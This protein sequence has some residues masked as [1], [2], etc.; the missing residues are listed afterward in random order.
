MTE[1]NKKI[2]FLCDFNISRVLNKLINYTI[3]NNNG[4]LKTRPY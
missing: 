2:G 4:G 3:S 1:G